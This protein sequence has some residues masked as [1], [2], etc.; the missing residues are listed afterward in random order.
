MQQKDNQINREVFRKPIEKQ[1][2][3]F[4]RHQK[5][6]E[7]H[8]FIPAML[9]QCKLKTMS[10]VERRTQPIELVARHVTQMCCLMRTSPARRIAC[11]ILSSFRYKSCSSSLSTDLFISSLSSSPCPAY[12]LILHI[13]LHFL[14][15]TRSILTRIRLTYRHSRFA[16]LR[17]ARGHYSKA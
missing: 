4:E 8:S 1:I 5:S 14:P 12:P 9:I 11:T 15:H 13:I 2:Y 16:D 7:S 3:A 6:I 10:A 17:A